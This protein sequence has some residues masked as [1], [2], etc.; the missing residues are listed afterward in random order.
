MDLEENLHYIVGSS[1]N[2]RFSDKGHDT[3]LPST[4]FY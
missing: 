4:I 3:F 2:L 1:Q